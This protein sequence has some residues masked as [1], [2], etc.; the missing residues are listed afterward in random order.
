MGNPNDYSFLRPSYVEN[1]QSKPRN[2]KEILQIERLERYIPG[3]L[4]NPPARTQP[5]EIKMNKDENLL[6]RNLENVKIPCQDEICSL[7]QCPKINKAKN[8]V[9]IPNM[10]CLCPKRKDAK[11]KDGCYAHLYKP[12]KKHD[13]M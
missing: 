6:Q 1:E 8:C 10:V 7:C 12:S 4:S 2:Y 13:F 3:K 5:M 9:E 11:R